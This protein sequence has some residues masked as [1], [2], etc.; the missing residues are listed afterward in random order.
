MNAYLLMTT[1]L[2]L[3]RRHHLVAHEEEDGRETFQTFSQVSAKVHV[4]RESVVPWYK[5]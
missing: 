3:D 1:Q 5:H 2:S 4:T